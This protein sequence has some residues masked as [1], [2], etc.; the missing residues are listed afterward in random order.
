MKPR[1]GRGIGAIRGTGVAAT[2]GQRRAGRGVDGGVEAQVEVVGF[3]EKIFGFVERPAAGDAVAGLCGDRKIAVA[4]AV[5]RIARVVAGV[6]Q[7]AFAAVGRETHADIAAAA[8]AVGFARAVVG[9]EG[10]G[11][12]RGVERMVAE[13]DEDFIFLGVEMLLVTHGDGVFER[14]AVVAHAEMAAAGVA[15]PHLRCGACEQ[16]GQCERREALP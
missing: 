13:E 16:C 3:A 6:V 7:P 9:V 8:V 12:D 4:G 14:H 5:E 10:R 15:G 11:D 2:G 1:N